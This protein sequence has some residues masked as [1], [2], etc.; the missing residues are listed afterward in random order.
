MVVLERLE[1]DVEAEGR[2][3]GL[4]AA[5]WAPMVFCEPAPTPAIPSASQNSQLLHLHISQCESAKYASQK[6]SQVSTRPSSGRKESHGTPSRHH[7]QPWHAHQSQCVRWKPTSHQGAQVACL[8]SPA[9]VE[10]HEHHSHCWHWQRAQ[11]VCLYVGEQKVWQSKTLTSSA[12]A[13]VHCSGAARVVLA[14]SAG[15]ARHIGHALH[16][17][18]SQCVSRNSSAHQGSHNSSALSPSTSDS[19]AQKPHAL[20]LHRPQWSA[21][22]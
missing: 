6:A 9:C 1:E 19:H 22:Y 12:S 2:A 13:G 14:M 11:C 8:A 3:V 20:H 10:L 4:V 7:S 21:L 16:L 18:W 17:H 15:A 5:P